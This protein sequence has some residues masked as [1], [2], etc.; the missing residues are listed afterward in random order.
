MSQTTIL[1]IPQIPQEIIDAVNDDKLAI[2]FWSWNFKVNRMQ[3]LEKT[4][5]DSC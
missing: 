3:R 2:F 4:C 5:R 1:D